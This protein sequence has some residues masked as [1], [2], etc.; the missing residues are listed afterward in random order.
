MFRH[1]SFTV[2]N[3]H[4]VDRY[5]LLIDLF[6]SNDDDFSIATL[7]M[8]SRLFGGTE[9]KVVGGSRPIVV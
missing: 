9:H 6:W 8:C 3:S 1:N 5:Y 2:H 7:M 4:S